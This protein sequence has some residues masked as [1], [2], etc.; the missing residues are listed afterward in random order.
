MLDFGIPKPKGESTSKSGYIRIRPR[1]VQSYGP[2]IVFFFGLATGFFGGFFAKLVPVV[3]HTSASC[4]L[5]VE[6]GLEAVS[7]QH[8]LMV[9][10]AVFVRLAS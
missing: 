7:L 9:A 4:R 3:R 5:P 6:A 10:K 8:S 1:L 2:G